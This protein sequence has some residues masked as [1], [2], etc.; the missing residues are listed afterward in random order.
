MTVQN[1]SILFISAVSPP[2][3]VVFFR[4]RRLRPT[5]QQQNMIC[6]LLAALFF[7]VVLGNHRRGQH[8]DRGSFESHQRNVTAH[9][10]SVSDLA[11]LPFYLALEVASDAMYFVQPQALVVVGGQ[12]K[13]VGTRRL[14][15]YKGTAYPFFT[16]VYNLTQQELERY[17]LLSDHPVKPLRAHLRNCGNMCVDE[18]LRVETEMAWIVQAKP[19]LHNVRLMGHLINAPASFINNTHCITITARF[20]LRYHA[21]RSSMIPYE[22]SSDCDYT[23]TDREVHSLNPRLNLTERPVLFK[24][25]DVRLIELPNGAIGAVYTINRIN[26]IRPQYY[27]GYIEFTLSPETQASGTLHIYRQFQLS[28][29]ILDDGKDRR[30]GFHNR[31]RTFGYKNWSPLVFNDTVMF[32]QK[33]NP[34]LVTTLSLSEMD[35]QGLS[36]EHNTS[37]I[38]MDLVSVAPSCAD[39]W[40]HGALRGGTPFLFIP[41]AGPWEGGAETDTAAAAAGAGASTAGLGFYLTFFHTLKYI[42]DQPRGT[43][44][45]GAMTVSASPPFRAL[46]ISP[47]PIIDKTMYT[48]KWMAQRFDYVYFPVGLMFALREAE[49]AVGS[50]SGSGSGSCAGSVAEHHA[51][52]NSNATAS[53]DESGSGGGFRGG[54]SWYNTTAAASAKILLYS[55]HFPKKALGS[56]CAAHPSSAQGSMAHRVWLVVFYGVQ[57]QDTYRAELNLCE[58]LAGLVRVQHNLEDVLGK[59][60]PGSAAGRWGWDPPKGY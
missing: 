4:E 27:L 58:V 12:I 15:P 30:E 3:S 5:L 23:S 31:F 6:F 37:Y 1:R 39:F 38:N 43:Y 18:R 32:V 44:W 54:S 49:P 25:E 48:G 24:S 51:N 19:L 46:R 47:G 41:I 13:E 16:T 20:P 59:F 26:A 45:W 7:D 34:L 33:L 21:Q 53:G 11:M 55:N 57:D 9:T 10:L 28:L 2:S 14:V 60:G 56:S 36:K 35:S 22:L 50:G 52:A 40:R 42:T 29:N 17:H 8:H